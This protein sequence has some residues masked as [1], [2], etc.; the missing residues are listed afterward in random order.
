MPSY[1]TGTVTK[2][3]SERP[4]LQRV[5]VDGAKA[6]VL[7]QLIGTVQEGDRVI[8]N[9]TAVELGLGTGGWD[10]VHWNLE[11]DEWSERGAGHE[12][13]LR[14][15]SSQ[16]DTGVS[17]A[18]TGAP[19]YAGAP[20]VACFLHSQIA[21]VAAT[22]KQAAPA[23]RL[24]YVMTEGGALPIAI[25]DL[26]DD[27]TRMGWIDVT[28]TA[29]QAFGGDREAVNVWHALEVASDCDA[30]V[31]GMGPGSL[32]SES[33]LGFSG[34]EVATVLQVAAKA[35]RRP[36]VALRWSDADARARHRGLS[37]HAV[38]ALR[39][40]DATAIVPVPKGGPKPEV[41]GHNVVEV[42]VPDVAGLFEDAGLDVRTMGRSPADDPGFFAFAGAAGVV[43][44]QRTR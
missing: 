23:A 37:H 14:Y 44:A 11:R 34:L 43:A 30:V 33:E 17:P 4:G 26:V 41:G 31:V 7:T 21:A 18:P 3:L 42:D 8:V 10:V 24:A 1:K 28:V 27:L 13:K 15:T 6:Y 36:I 39:L 29:G 16:V 35:D 32:G 5:E 19:S 38:T 2:L 9:T 12:M 22:F 25:S 40:T 20:L